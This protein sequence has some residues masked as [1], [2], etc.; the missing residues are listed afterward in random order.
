M[1]RAA[2]DAGVDIV[3]FQSWQAKYV[4]DTDPDKKRYEGLELSDDDHK[5][6]IKECKKAGVEFLT[7]CFDTARIPFLKS[8][9]LNSIK[10]PSYDL[11]ETKRLRALV[12]NFDHI[13]VSTGMST[14]KEIEEGMKI[15]ASA[16]KYTI[17]HC[18]SVYPTPPEMANLKKIEWLK[19][20][21]PSVGYSDHT[22]GVDAPIIAMSMGVEYLEKHFTLSKYLPQ[23]LHT[24]A[25]GKRPST[26][27]EVASEPHIFKEICQWRDKIDSMLGEGKI[28]ILPQEK[29]TRDKYTGRL[30]DSQFT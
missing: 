7:T 23:E 16:K 13:F 12:E 21:H 26:T 10:I 3:K 14:Q 11:K 17:M 30:G 28:E 22:D 15:L 27:H 29:A 24:T 18:V 20:R 8:L 6:L 25:D 9:G 2:A 1:I 5:F 19:D 4:K